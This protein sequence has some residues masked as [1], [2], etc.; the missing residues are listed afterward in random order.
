[1]PLIGIIG[2]ME[3]EIVGI[4][5]AM[6][7]ITTRSIAQISFHVGRL[8]DKEVV[9]ARCG[10]G[11][12]NA[13]MCTQAMLDK[14]PVLHIINLGVAGA[15]NNSLNIKD[16]VVS[17]SL[18]QHDF[19]IT[20]VGHPPGH[21]PA[22]GVELHADKDLAEAALAV[23][24]E[25]F[26]GST[27]TAYLATIATGDQFVADKNVKERIHSNFDA[28]CVEMEGAAIAQVCHLNQVPFVVIRAISD[29]ADGSA[30]MDFEEFLTA[31]AAN[32]SKIV[33]R[34]VSSL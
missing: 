14:F 7:D 32:S 2:A 4:L 5:A 13:A 24:K 33:A 8:G 34:L 19:D 9:L 16:V 6:T 30:D 10:V 18:V 21:V 31:A 28:Y 20:A 17:T 11:K 12:V 1:M 22:L 29:K 26:K 3:V 25:I 23:C 15:I 27:S